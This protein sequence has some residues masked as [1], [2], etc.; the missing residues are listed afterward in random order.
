[1]EVSKI[2]LYSALIVEFVLAI[3]F[4]NFIINTS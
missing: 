2:E 4:F 1:M 3:N